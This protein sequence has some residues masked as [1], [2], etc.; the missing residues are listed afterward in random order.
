ML[1]GRLENAEKIR[2]K[3]VTRWADEGNMER[4]NEIVGFSVATS[5]I[6]R[7]IVPTFYSSEDC[8][9]FLAFCGFVL[10]SLKFQNFKIFEF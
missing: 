4:T 7:I 8:C 5:A 9:F 6:I 3:G 10:Q 1:E 2:N